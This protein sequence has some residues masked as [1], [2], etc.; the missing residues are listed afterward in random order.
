MP[1]KFEPENELLDDWNRRY[2]NTWISAP[3]PSCLEAVSATLTASEVRAIFQ[4][5]KGKSV[6]ENP[7]LLKKNDISSLM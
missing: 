6:L 7:S 4:C 1:L 2:S 3:P 5:P